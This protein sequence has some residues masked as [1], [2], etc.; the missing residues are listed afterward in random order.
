[1]KIIN[2]YLH[3]KECI[4]LKEGFYKFLEKF[5]HNDMEY[6]IIEVEYNR[7]VIVSKDN[8]L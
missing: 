8:L 6:F 2:F 1:M 3:V 7:L 4:D 5:A